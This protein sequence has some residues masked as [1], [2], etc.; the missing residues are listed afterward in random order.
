MVRVVAKDLRSPGFLVEDVMTRDIFTTTPD[1]LL[2]ELKRQMRAR[3]IRHVPVVEN[4]EVLAVLSMRD[5]M[6]AA[7]REKGE[8]VEH[9]THYIQG[10]ELV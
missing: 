9:M 10:N 4:G 3:H 6:R 1:E 8:Q 7:L 2:V 5:L